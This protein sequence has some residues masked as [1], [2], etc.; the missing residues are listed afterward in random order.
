MTG[1]WEFVWAPIRMAL[2]LLPC[3]LGLRPGRAACGRRG[4]FGGFAPFG[5]LRISGGHEK[6]RL[7]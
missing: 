1:V 6:G 3:R 4:G 5:I 2:C 7:A